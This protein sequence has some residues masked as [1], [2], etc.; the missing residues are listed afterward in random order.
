M[1]VREVDGSGFDNV[2]RAPILASPSL[3]AVVPLVTHRNRRESAFSDSAVY[4][5]SSIKSLNARSAALLE[6]PSGLAK[7]LLFSLPARLLT[8]RVNGNGH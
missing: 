4:A 3:P 8:L 7:T 5:F 1:R 2:P 6:W